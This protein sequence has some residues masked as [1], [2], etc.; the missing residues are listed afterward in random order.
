MADR[1]LKLRDLRKILTRYGVGENTSRGKGSHTVFFK[2]IGGGTYTYPVPTSGQDV[3]A[4]YAKGC[5]VKFKLTE[6][7][8]VTDAEFYGD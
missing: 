6:A 4:C 8:G 1:V 2:R 7:D 5:R 3:L